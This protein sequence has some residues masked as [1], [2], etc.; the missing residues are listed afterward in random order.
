MNNV[1]SYLE[2]VDQFNNQH[3]DFRYTKKGPIAKAQG[4]WYSVNGSA[5]DITDVRH[6]LNEEELKEF[7]VTNDQPVQ[8]FW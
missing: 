6:A 5:R 4:I 8:V 7:K 3:T 2:Y 1:L